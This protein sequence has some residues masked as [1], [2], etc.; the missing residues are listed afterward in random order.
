MALYKQASATSQVKIGAG[1]LYGIQISSTSSGTLTVYDSALSS[2]GDP[3]IAATI[4]PTA[5]A[6]VLSFPPGIFFGKGLY[7]VAA[8]TIEYTVVYE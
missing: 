7:I 4:T 6:Q 3:K 5:G 8:N 2:T 1:K